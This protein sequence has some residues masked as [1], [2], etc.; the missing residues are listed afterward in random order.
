M[1]D[2]FWSTWVQPIP[3]LELSRSPSMKG[4][5]TPSSNTCRTLRPSPGRWSGS[6]GRMEG[7]PARAEA[8]ELFRL[9]RERQE[10]RLRE[11]RAGVRRWAIEGRPSLIVSGRK[12]GAA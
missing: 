11:L 8:E 7:S 10:R 2:D 1:D 5:L 12:G 9:V 6:A 3:V 4:P